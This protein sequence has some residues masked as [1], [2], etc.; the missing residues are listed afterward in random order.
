[1]I[2]RSCSP[3]LAGWLFAFFLPP[4]LALPPFPHGPD[5]HQGQH[6]DVQVTGVGMW[7]KAFL[8]IKAHHGIVVFV[9]VPDEWVLLLWTEA[10]VHPVV[11]GCSSSTTTSSTGEWW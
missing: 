4:L 6:G 8:G 3:L 10:G 2:L 7:L 1:M 9:V 11:V 5:A